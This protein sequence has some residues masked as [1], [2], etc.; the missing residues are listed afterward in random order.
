[1]SSKEDAES[2]EPWYDFTQGVSMHG[3]KHANTRKFAVFRRV[4]WVCLILLSLSYF[5]GASSTFLTD[6]AKKKLITNIRVEKANQ[7]TFPTIT[8]CNNNNWRR[9]VLYHSSLDLGS[10]VLFEVVQDLYNEDRPVPPPADKYNMSDPFY[11]PAL[12]LNATTFTQFFKV[13]AHP[14]TTSL[15]T[16]TIFGRNYSC[17]DVFEVVATD[18]GFCYQFNSNGTLNASAPGKIG[19]IA[20]MLQASVEEYSTGPNSFSEGFSLTFHNSYEV[21]QVNE[22]GV[23]LSPGTQASIMLHKSETQR[24]PPPA[25]HGRAN[26]LDT[27]TIPNSLKYYTQ[28]SYSGCMVECK[29]KYVI[30]RCGCRDFLQPENFASDEEGLEA[31]SCPDTCHDNEFVPK[32]STYKFPS[33]N[34][35]EEM[36][37]DKTI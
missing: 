21:P 4:A 10:Y 13:A 11:A 30:D 18:A 31:C 29:A 24:Y 25:D 33:A 26:C 1:M 7:L 37:L 14:L 27:S 5:L 6:F 9:S 22:Q 35:I 19:G 2:G 32:V 17:S 20:I 16:C 28:Y 36:Q 23:G 34:Y 3:L 12:A 15:L 8:I